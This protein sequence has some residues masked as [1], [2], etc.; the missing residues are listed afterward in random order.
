MN[1]KKYKSNIQV[2]YTKLTLEKEKH[3]VVVNTIKRIKRSVAGKQ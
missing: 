2:F 1:E 3:L